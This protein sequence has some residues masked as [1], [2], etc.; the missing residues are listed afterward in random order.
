MVLQKIKKGKGVTDKDIESLVSI[1]LEQIPHFSVQQLEKL[2]PDMASDLNV[3]IRN[4]VGI[5][6]QEINQRIEEFQ[7]QYT[8]LTTAQMQC[9][10]LIK[11]QLSANKYIKPESFYDKPFTLLGSISDIFSKQQMDD[12]YKMLEG[13]IIGGNNDR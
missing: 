13:F 5:D 4:I 10:K 12:I 9:L 7:H 8:T 2:Y 6:E 1:I 3:L 11:S